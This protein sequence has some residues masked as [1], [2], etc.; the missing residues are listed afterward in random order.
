MI[1]NMW[2]LFLGKRGFFGNLLLEHIEI[3][4]L[5]I[6]IAVILGGLAGILISEFQKTAKPTLGVINFL[7]TIPSI[8]M[9]GFLI[10]FSGIG[11]AT[12]VIALTVYALLPMV[13]NTYTGICNI[14]G[15][16]IEAAEGMGSTRF[17]ILYKVKLPLAMPV[18]LS[19]I[20]NMVTMTI[21]LAGIASFIGAGGLGVAIYRGITTNNTAMT[22]VGSLLIAVLALVVDLLLGCVEKRI[23][24]RTTKKGITTGGNKNNIK[25]LAVLLGMIAVIVC[26]VLTAVF[27]KGKKDTIHIATKPM[28]EQYILGEM[29]DILIEQDTDL[30]VEVTEGV[31]GGTSNIQPA[32]E[33][34]EFDLYPEYTGTGW[35]M[36]LKKDGIYSED[37]F[38]KLQKEYEDSL[39]MQWFG[40]YGFNNTYGLVVRKEI[41][42]KYNIETYSDLKA[43]AD[44][45]TFGAE[46]D[47][48]EREDGYDALCKT[49]GFNFKK[50][51]DMDIGL[52]YQAIN[53]GKIDVMVIFTTD[54]QL[55]VSDVKVLKDDKEFYPSYMCGNVVRN[56]VL[57]KHPEL[58]RELKKL[59]GTITDSDMAQMN[60]E[61]ETE[62]KEPRDVA[63]EFL[64]SAGLV[65]QR[66][67]K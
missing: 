8:S 47:F 14:D 46:Y 48:F 24:G 61:V 57:K 17:Q 6:I 29:L 28:T 49:Y 11:N 36:V 37:S 20:R 35:N 9:L 18:I 15:N 53:Q 62:K 64:K 43:I 30:N 12:A 55:A 27:S 52:K 50:T 45:L 7:Y 23:A 60:Y 34:G 56:E 38:A 39:D 22:M 31:G 63:R 59:S 65:K 1:Q 25:K 2:T 41:A 32:M 51:M 3:S 5:A 33:S 10:P 67:Q 19:G 16:I 44:Q 58:K 26:V 54:G 66:G 40:M 21:A 13:R 4:L 42:E